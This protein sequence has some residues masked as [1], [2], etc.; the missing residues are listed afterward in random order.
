M[1]YFESL[2]KTYN[3]LPAKIL[4]EDFHAS[5][6]SWND[7]LSYSFGRADITT[8]VSSC[9]RWRKQDS[10]FMKSTFVIWFFLSLLSTLI[11]SD[12]DK[13]RNVYSHWPLKFTQP[14]LAEIQNTSLKICYILPQSLLQT[15]AWVALSS[16]GSIITEM[17]KKR[18]YKH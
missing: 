18:T 17:G 13:Y 7:L 1:E 10:V 9:W 6:P 3:I 4:L 16:I 5:L 11:D 8:I 2:Q 14:F 12:T 15:E